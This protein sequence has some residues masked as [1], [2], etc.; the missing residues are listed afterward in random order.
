ML[1][2]E[3]EWARPARYQ[4]QAGPPGTFIT[5]RAVWA[6]CE[7]AEPAIGRLEAPAFL[8]HGT[9]EVEPSEI[10]HP[11]QPTIAQDSG[12]R[13]AHGVADLRR[14]REKVPS[15]RQR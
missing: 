9:R 7:P 12:R 10:I 5:R 15:P 4:L 14:A 8:H 13:L 3:T 2:A 11:S 6:G 1:T